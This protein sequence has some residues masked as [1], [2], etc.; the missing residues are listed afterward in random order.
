MV[1]KGTALKD[2]CT[3]TG[4]PIQSVQWLKDGEEANQSIALTENEY[5][6]Y[7]LKAVGHQSFERDFKIDILCKYLGNSALLLLS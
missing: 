4:R 5:G 6:N 2:V 7:T 1:K 3:V